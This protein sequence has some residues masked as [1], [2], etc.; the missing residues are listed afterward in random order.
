MALAIDHFISIS[1]FTGRA[2]TLVDTLGI[3]WAVTIVNVTLV[4]VTAVLTV[5]EPPS[6]ARALE[7]AAFI[8]T[9]SMLV[10]V[11]ASCLTLIL[12]ALWHADA[13]VIGG[14]TLIT[15]TAMSNTLI[16]A[17]RVDRT[18]DGV[19][20]VSIA[21]AVPVTVEAIFTGALIATA[22]IGTN[23]ISVT[24]AQAQ[25]ALI[26]ITRRYTT[27]HLINKAFSALACVAFA[28]VNAD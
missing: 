4:F 25:C 17:V 14:V 26:L 18:L 15:V 6:F 10:T 8:R 12:V 21:T 1:T 9:K 16:Y 19:T 20:H 22:E 7:S 27:A 2:N 5:T 24:L 11:M 3:I 23:G 28:G 13:I